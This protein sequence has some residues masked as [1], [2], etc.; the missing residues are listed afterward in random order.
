MKKVLEIIGLLFVCMISA[1]NEKT[2]V[3]KETVRSFTPVDSKFEFYYVDNDSIKSDICFSIGR[4]KK[5]LFLEYDRLLDELSLVNMV[6]DTCAVGEIKED[7]SIG[8]FPGTKELLRLMSLCLKKASEKYDISTLSTISASISD[9]PEIDVE[10]TY[11]LKK[12][13]RDPIRPNNEDIKKAI[14]A[15]TLRKDL[16]KVLKPYGIK[17]KSIEPPLVN[18]ILG[19]SKKSVLE[20][21]NID[22]KVIIPDTVLNTLLTINMRKIQNK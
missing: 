15:T 16:N 14:E 17:V 19:S 7:K 8:K 5:G 13:S 3:P 22:P 12:I 11:Q 4:F 21:Y 20:L 18:I 10:Y 9:F 6:Q 1:C 2:V